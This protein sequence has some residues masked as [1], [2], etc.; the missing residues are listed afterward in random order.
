MTQ[1]KNPPR[2]AFIGGGHITEILLD[3]WVSGGVVAPEQAVVSSRG[4]ERLTKLRERFEVAI[5]QDN[6]AAVQ[7]ADLIFINVRPEVVETVVGE[8][9]TTDLTPHQLII[10]L[11]AGIPLAKYGRL[12]PQQPLVRA[13]PNPPSRIGQGLI[14]LHLS[15]HVTKT[16]R[17]MVQNLF[18]T[19]G[20]VVE[21]EEAHFNVITALTSPVA[22][23]LFFQSLIE[24]GVRGGLKRPLA[25]QIAAQ[26]LIGS[27]G[28]WQ[29]GDEPPYGLIA[30]ASTPGG[31]SVEVLYTLEKLGLKTA[32][33]DAIAQGTNRAEQLS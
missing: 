14:A 5:L 13:M 6:V 31:I 12:S 3:N 15:P 23:Y 25:A 19:L 28:V 9:R 7:G 18:S 4:K 27:L 1:F 30:E 11:A 32:V 10:S 24:A 16:Q 29:T 20:Q 17:T 22:T 2:L 8:L 26:T 33:M 21:V